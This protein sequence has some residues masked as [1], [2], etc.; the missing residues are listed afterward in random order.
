MSEPQS[1]DDLR[2]AESWLES[3]DNCS[4]QEGR[5]MCTRF[6]FTVKNMDVVRC[7]YWEAYQARRD[8]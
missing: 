5:H 7:D 1:P 8:S 6:G 2:P 3:C 4:N